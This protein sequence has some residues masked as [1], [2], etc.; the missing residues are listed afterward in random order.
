MFL[1]LWGLHSFSLNPLIPLS[2]I[3]LLLHFLS[4]APQS[5]SVS[6][7]TRNP[8]LLPIQEFHHLMSL[9]CVT[10]GYH[11]AAGG[12]GVWAVAVLFL[13]TIMAAGFF[14]LYKFKR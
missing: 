9:C 11:G 5:E 10:L 8:A 6:V 3:N 12:P 2:S 4:P 14:I 7:H 13:I 1:Y